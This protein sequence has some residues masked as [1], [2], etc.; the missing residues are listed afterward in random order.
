M[1]V[2][3]ICVYICC[4]VGL[5]P[6]I[7]QPSKSDLLMAAQF[8]QYEVR[9]LQIPK[10]KHA[11]PPFRWDE[12]QGMW[13]SDVK[14]N[15]HGNPDYALFRQ[16]FGIFD[17]N[18]FATTYI[19]ACVAETKRYM[20]D[21][22]HNDTSYGL[23]NG[24]NAIKRHH[25]LNVNYSNSL[26]TFWP[27]TYNDESKVYN[28]YPVNLN[29]AIKLTEH[30]P[31]NAT[32]AFLE[33]LGLK[34]VDKI[35]QEVMRI[36]GVY[37]LAF[38]IPPDF[39]DTFLN[40]GLGS[41]LAEMAKE[42][43]R[44]FKLW[45][46]HNTNLTS[47]F[48]ALKY[49]A[50]RP[51]SGDQR[52]NTI[53]TRSYY[54]L[55]PWLE[56]EKAAGRDVAL[57]PT[58]IQDT[59][60]VR[61]W[62]DKGVMMPFNINNVDVTVCANFIYALT[63]GIITGVLQPSLLDDP[64]VMHIYNDTARMIAFQVSTNFS[65]RADLALTY[66]PSVIEF[67]WFVART[68]NKLQ[69]TLDRTGS[70]P[71]KG[72]DQILADFKDVLRTYASPRILDLGTPSSMY[73]FSTLYYDDFL[74][75]ADI[76]YSNKSAPDPEDRI[77]T[78]A[79]AMTALLTIW[80]TQDQHTG[81]MIWDADTPLDIK[82]AAN[83]TATWLYYNING[84]QPLLAWNAFFSGSFKGYTTDT[85][86]YPMN[87][88]E[89]F[90]GTRINKTEIRNEKFIQGVEGFIPE[91]EYKQMMEKLH[92]PTVFPGYNYNGDFFPFW[93]SEAYTYAIGML[94]LGKYIGTL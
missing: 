3:E 57:V 68:Y 35:V 88:L 8:L 75:D 6:C 42:F 61:T 93:S 64:E 17:N 71:H 60:E 90:N 13:P 32:Y 58:W 2:R 29:D 28:S 36:R 83:M 56:Q 27:Q 19:M 33:R 73:N 45:S 10:T 77:F 82:R 26:M 72:M 91:N 9:D 46:S 85:F 63:S 25:D 48:D 92:T 11:F 4:L 49:Y 31:L 43:P 41:I 54:Y 15:F 20:D 79:M 55:R 65:D 38:H 80:T 69:E 16:I 87:R 74:G 81:K 67:Y 53:D 51:F 89:L 7:A 86:H 24:I 66:Y 34:D 18:M 59:D 50:Y 40:I 52:V 22:W 5:V 23:M 30:L 84:E 78:T 12:E 94:G 62:Y 76:D 39:D 14:M 21:R 37:T 1:I 44:A 70:L 47:V